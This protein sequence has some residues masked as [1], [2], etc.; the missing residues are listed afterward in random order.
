MKR[1]PV[2]ELTADKASA[3]KTNESI[4]DVWNSVVQLWNDTSHFTDGNTGGIDMSKGEIF[5]LAVYWALGMTGVTTAWFKGAKL[6]S[7]LKEFPG[8]AK[9]FLNLAKAFKSSGT[10]DDLKKN[11]TDQGLDFSKVE[12]AAANESMILEAKRG[13]PLN[14]DANPAL[15]EVYELVCNVYCAYDGGCTAE[16]TAE[17]ANAVLKKELGLEE[18]FFKDDADYKSKWETVEGWG[19]SLKK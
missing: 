12:K 6:A 9:K 11:M 4:A 14:E 18:D 16:C 8:K 2:F 13:K 10:I 17:E 19:K 7:M 5:R 1:I 3:T 15:D